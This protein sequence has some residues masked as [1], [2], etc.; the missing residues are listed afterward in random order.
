[1]TRTWLPSDTRQRIQ[2]LIKDSL[3]IIHSK[4]PRYILYHLC[5]HRLICIFFIKQ[6][7]CTSEC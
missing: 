2:D 5:N 4:T 1:M 7:E 3:L 6:E